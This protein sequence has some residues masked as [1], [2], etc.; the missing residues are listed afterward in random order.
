[1]A[2]IF[3]RLKRFCPLRKLDR[4]FATKN[5]C[6]KQPNIFSVSL[7]RRVS[8]ASLAHPIS[9]DRRFQSSKRPTVVNLS[10]TRFYNPFT[11]LRF[12]TIITVSEMSRSSSVP[13]IYVIV[14]VAEPR[15]AI[16]DRKT[17]QSKRM[18]GTR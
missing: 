18:T 17:F 13:G 3:N 4:G 10:F 12:K 6:T 1:M 5:L 2:V 9:S 16:K 7:S 8:L 15:H 14:C 11:V